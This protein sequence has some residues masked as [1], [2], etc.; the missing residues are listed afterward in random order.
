MI[1]ARGQQLADDVLGGAVAAPPVGWVVPLIT[2]QV[3]WMIDV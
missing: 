2:S 1:A 3:V